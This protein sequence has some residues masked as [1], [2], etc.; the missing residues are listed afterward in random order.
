MCVARDRASQREQCRLEALIRL[1]EAE[2]QRTLLTSARFKT[3]STTSSGCFFHGDG[4]AR[5]DTRL[6]LLRL[7]VLHSL[8]WIARRRSAAGKGMGGW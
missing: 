1:V 6:L 8:A 4:M 3:L 2:S 5:E 7:V